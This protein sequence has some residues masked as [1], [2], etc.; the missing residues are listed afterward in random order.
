[1]FRRIRFPF[2]LAVLDWGRGYSGRAKK[3]EISY[4][5]V[6]S[7]GHAILIELFASNLFSPKW[8]ESAYIFNGNSMR[9]LTNPWKPTKDPGSYGAFLNG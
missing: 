9:Y 2:V 8:Q 3:R 1:M 6:K 7:I 5:L 4:E